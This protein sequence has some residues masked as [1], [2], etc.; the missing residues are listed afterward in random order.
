MTF[1]V[2]FFDGINDTEREIAALVR[3]AHQFPCTVNV[4]PYHSIGFTG[5][6]G[7]PASLRPSLRL[8]QI[9]QELRS[10]HVTVLVRSSAGEDIEAACG[11]LAVVPGSDGR[12]GQHTTRSHTH[13]VSVHSRSTV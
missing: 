11:Q 7:F 13:H 1:E 3:L 12:R 9:V 2:I 5:V 8:E 4:I 6:T 10:K